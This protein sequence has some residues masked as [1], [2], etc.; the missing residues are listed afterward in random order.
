MKRTVFLILLLTF[1][2]RMI[3]Q[4]SIVPPAP[5]QHK[6]DSLFPGAKST[7]W[8]MNGADYVAGFKM[9]LKD[10]K[11]KFTKDGTYLEKHLAI[12]QSALPEAARNYI[13]SKYPGQNVTDVYKVTKA[14]GTI[15]YISTVGGKPL[16]FDS[17]GN[18]VQPLVTAAVPKKTP[19]KAPVKAK[20]K[21]GK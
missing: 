11:A 5:V 10:M 2:V 8:S 3:A 14:N 15:N 21:S 20:S 6:F 19:V 4:S 17:A 18:F 13:L 16:K 12:Q 9:D 7:T 1:S